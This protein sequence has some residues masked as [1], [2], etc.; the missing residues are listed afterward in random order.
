MNDRSQLTGFRAANQAEA[1]REAES[2]LRDLNLDPDQYDVRERNARPIGSQQAGT[3]DAAQGGIVD[4]AGETPAQPQGQFT[5]EWKIVDPNG[6]EIYRFS[7]VGNAQSDANRVAMQWLQRNPRQMQAG[8]EV[9][10]VM[11]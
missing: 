4:V 5:G 11:G 1:E 2:I 8:V 7:G 10:P 9:L 3:A 6:R